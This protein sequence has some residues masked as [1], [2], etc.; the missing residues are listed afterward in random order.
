MQMKEYLGRL[1]QS[2][3][4]MSFSKMFCVYVISEQDARVLAAEGSVK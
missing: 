3:F 4:T 2:S 1:L